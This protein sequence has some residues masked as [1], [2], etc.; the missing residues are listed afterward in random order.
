M[1][2]KGETMIK[3]LKTIII[4]NF[5]DCLFTYIIIKTGIGIEVNPVV[6]FILSSDLYFFVFVMVKNF[7][8]YLICSLLASKHDFL[9]MKVVSYTAFGIY[10][11]A[12]INHFFVFI[13]HLNSI[14]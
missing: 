4:L 2:N 5:L 12:T 14:I 8:I 7:V 6:R 3:I 13:S 10:V 1:T 11:F 9:S